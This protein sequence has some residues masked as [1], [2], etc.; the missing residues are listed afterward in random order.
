MYFVIIATDKPG[1]GQARLEAMVGLRDWL[2]NHPE[3]PDVTVHH[4]G[5][6]LDDDGETM[7]GT[8]NVIEAPSLEAARAFAADSPL[9]KADIF[10]EFHVRPWDWR[11]GSQAR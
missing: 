7:N 6:T 10:A 1:T 8:V 5:P 9:R 3:H 11:L 2:D 4:A